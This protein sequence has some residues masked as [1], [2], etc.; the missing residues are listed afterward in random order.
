MQETTKVIL[1][2]IGVSTWEG[3]RGRVLMLSLRRS[4]RCPLEFTQLFFSRRFCEYGWPKYASLR[5]LLQ[6]RDRG[7]RCIKSILN[8]FALGV[9]T[10]SE[11]II[12]LGSVSSSR[13]CLNTFLTNWCCQIHNYILSNLHLPPI[14]FVN[15]YWK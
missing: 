14:D 3:F 12:S 1:W 7:S 4:G 15:G 13:K 2:I 8:L 9:T 10:R 5:K 6:V 11:L